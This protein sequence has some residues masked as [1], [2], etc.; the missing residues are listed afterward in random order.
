MTHTI[1]PMKKKISEDLCIIEFK[2]EHSKIFKDL[3]IAW[4]SKSFFVEESDE[5]VLSDPEKYILEG[6]GAILLAKY[7]EEIVGT[8]ALT[9]EDHNIYELT[10]MAVDENFR[11]LKI[12]YHLG[13][14]TLEKAKLIGAE[15]VILHS[16]KKGSA[17][18]I[19]LYYK[20][21]F[22]EIPLGNAPWARADIKMEI[23]V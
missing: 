5:T 2:T 21:G 4:I 19:Q 16:N 8:C 18:A 17:A 22:K 20:L 10:K 11:G 23:L 7:K 15:K 14:A 1:S 12:G 13:V 9:Y 6:G 3:N